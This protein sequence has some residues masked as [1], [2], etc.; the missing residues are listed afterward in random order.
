MSLLP[1][2]EVHMHRLPEHVV[3]NLE[4]LLADERILVRQRE[5]I[6]SRLPRQRKGEGPRS[7]ASRNARSTISS[8]LG[9]E[10]PMTMSSGRSITD[11]WGSKS[12]P[13]SSAGKA[14]LPTMTGCTNSTETCWASVAAEPLPKA[15]SRPPA[16]KR[17]DISWQASARRGASALKKLSKTP[18]RRS[19]SSLLRAARIS[20]STC[21]TASTSDDQGASGHEPGFRWLSLQLV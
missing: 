16:R 1:V 17:R 18:L 10:K 8:P 14:R 5:G 4:D 11:R 2:L 21:R 12:G 15:R 7:R 20:V 3:Q 9:N 13:T 19:N 6:V